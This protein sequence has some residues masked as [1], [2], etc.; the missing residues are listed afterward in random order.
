MANHMITFLKLLNL[1]LTLLADIK[2]NT[3]KSH[4]N[5]ETAW[6]GQ[7]D[8][9]SPASTGSPLLIIRLSCVHVHIYIYI[10]YIYTY[11]MWKAIRLLILIVL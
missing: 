8:L 10:L 6:S 3:R 2:Q 4:V 9:S 7:V 1:F 5:N 11:I